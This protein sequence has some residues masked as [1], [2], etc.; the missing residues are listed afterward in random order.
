M[1]SEYI[2]LEH[3]IQ[4]GA[5]EL[6]KRLATELHES[7]SSQG[8]GFGL[9]SYCGATRLAH[10]WFPSWAECYSSMIGELL[11]QLRNKGGRFTTLCALGEEMRIKY[12]HHNDCIYFV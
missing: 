2:E 7:E 10:G 1:I 9:P 12:V 8:F 11:A 4:D 3:G 6:A 5:K